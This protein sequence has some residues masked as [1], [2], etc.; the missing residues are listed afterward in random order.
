MKTGNAQTKGSR[1][2]EFALPGAAVGA[3]AP[4]RSRGEGM[5]CGMVRGGAEG[6]KIA[7]VPKS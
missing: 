6:R 3:A 1:T 5:R 4:R 7:R 2:R